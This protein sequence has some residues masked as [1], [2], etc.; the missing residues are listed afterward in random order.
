MSYRLDN[1]PMQPSQASSLVSPHQFVSSPFIQNTPATEKIAF[2]LNRNARKVSEGAIKKIQRLVPTEDLYISHSLEES[3]HIARVIVQKGYGTVVSGGGDGTLCNVMNQ[4]CRYVDE[5]NDWRKQ[6]AR[7]Y[8]DTS[9]LVSYPEFAFLKLG[10]GNG[11]AEVV[12]AADFAQ[13]IQKL[14]TG[15]RHSSV[16]VD[17]IESEGKRFMFAGMGYDA[18]VLN[19]YVNLKKW[20]KNK[21]LINTVAGTVAGYLLAVVGRTVPDMIARGCM[22]RIRVTN[23]GDTAYWIDGRRGDR[24]IAIEK[25]EVIFEGEAGLAGVG[26]HPYYGFGFKVYPFAGIMPGYMNLRIANMG[27]LSVLSKLP[28]IWNGTCR[29]KHLFD[30]LVKEIKIESKEPMPYQFAGDAQGQ[31]T[32]IHFKISDIPAQLVDYRGSLIA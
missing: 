4:I 10:T 23:L 9:G 13:D 6:R 28:S 32:S 27:P 11:L 7:F 24:A 26:T 1:Q 2:V 21:P 20:A 17:M 15:P 22:Q 25:G 19:D 8:N 12:G 3:E 31:R 18:W 16:A 5:T 29:T 14:Q 30:F